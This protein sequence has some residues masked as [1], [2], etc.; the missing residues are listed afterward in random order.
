MNDQLA[1]TIC[2]VMVCVAAVAGAWVTGNANALWALLIVPM[3][4]H[5]PQ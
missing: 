3:V 5:S 1:R 2:G 4:F